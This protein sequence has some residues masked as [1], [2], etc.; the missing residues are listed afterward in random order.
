MVSLLFGANNRQKEATEMFAYMNIRHT[1]ASF[2]VVDGSHWIQRI[3]VI[4][5]LDNSNKKT[6]LM[7]WDKDV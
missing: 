5:S 6:H 3:S 4:D 7:V 1:R 2:Y